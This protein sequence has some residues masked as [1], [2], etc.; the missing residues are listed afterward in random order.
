MK[1]I[2]FIIIAVFFTANIHG[3]KN[4]YVTILKSLP[5]AADYVLATEKEKEMY[6]EKLSNIRAALSEYQ[7]KFQNIEE[8]KQTPSE[9]NSL[10]SV[11]QE[12]ES[13]NEKHINKFLENMLG[14]WSD[15]YN[16]NMVLMLDLNKANQPYYEQIRALISKPKSAENDKL[17]RNLR[18]KIYDSKLQLYPTLQN[19]SNDFLKQ[20]FAELN[21]ITLYVNKLDSMLLTVIKQP[22][23]G[24]GPILL[25]N[26]VGILDETFFLYHLGSFEEYL[27]DAW[28]PDYIF[29][30][31][32]M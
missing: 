10:E 32:P 5:P 12:Y 22:S 17:I 25:D 21:S 3:Q 6:R 19:E 14:K 4:D 27:K 7:S 8:R 28:N 20:S 31:F 13:I 15:I 29:I 30:G 1:K 26:Y 23:A 18:R 24:V 9:Y 2:Y 11:L 16:N